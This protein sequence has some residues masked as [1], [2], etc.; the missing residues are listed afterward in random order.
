MRKTIN[1][2]LEN[3]DNTTINL[4]IDDNIISIIIGR[5]ESIQNIYLHNTAVDLYGRQDVNVPAIKISTYHRSTDYN[6]TASDKF[7]TTI[8]AGV[9]AFFAGGIYS[10]LYEN[11]VTGYLMLV[12][13]GGAMLGSGAVHIY[14]NL[15]GPETNITENTFETDIPGNKS[16][17]Y[18]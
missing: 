9:G 2:K 1:G 7:K 4:H 10:K 6:G 17:K 5:G 14:N 11:P 12:A 3:P 18:P 16:G 15:K 8:G 13:V